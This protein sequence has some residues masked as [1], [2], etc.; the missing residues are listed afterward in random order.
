[1]DKSHPHPAPQRLMNWD[2]LLLWQG[3]FVSFIGTQVFLISMIFWMKHQT[4]SATWVGMVTMASTLP[5]ALLGPLGGTFADRYPRRRILLATD[6]ASGFLSLGLAALVMALPDRP[7]LIL[8]GL[9][10][11]A[12]LM[13]ALGSF[14]RP[15]ITAAI[16]DLV[17]PEKITQANS[18]MGVSMSASNFIGQAF[19]GVL[20]RLLGPGL[21]FVFN[22]VSY[23]FSGVS[24]IFIRIPQKI[25][26]K[27]AGGRR[28][29][30]DMRAETLQGLRYIWADRGL[31]ALLLV[32]VNDMIFL[33]AISV[34]F[35][36]FVEDHLGADPDWYGYL[37]A[38]FGAGNVLG[39]I[40]AGV[41]KL[42]GRTRVRLIVVGGTLAA[43]SA[44]TLG[45][46]VD[47]NW[48]ALFVLLAAGTFLGFND[49]H[50]LS[51]IQLASRKD[52]RGRVLGLFGTIGLAATPVAAGL[53]GIVTDLL[54]QDI[55]TFYAICGIGLGLSP[56]IVLTSTRGRAHLAYEKVPADEGRPETTVS[57]KEREREKGMKRVVK[58]LA[59]AAAT[60]LIIL[61]VT[62]VYFVRRPW[63]QADGELRVAGLEAPV[64][65]IRDEWGV[66][67]VYA[68]SEHDLFFAQGFVH[69]QDRLWQMHMGRV[70]GSGR[71]ATLF[72]E[73]VV[74][75]DRTFR[76][77]SLRWAAERDWEKLDDELRDMLE[78]YSA[79]VNAYIDSN[80]G[81]TGL[82]FRLLGV[83]PEPWT[84]V[85]T[86]TWTKM[87]SLNIGLNV[88]REMARVQLRTRLG[89]K[90]GA[91]ADER[92][93]G[94]YPDDAPVIV[95]PAPPPSGA[96]PPVPE[97]SPPPG[98]GAVAQDREAR[99]P[100]AAWT[101][102]TRLARLEPTAGLGRLSPLLGDA[103]SWGSNAWVVHGSRTASGKP[104]LANDTHL[105]LGLPSVWYENGLHGGRFDVVGFSF[106]GLPT[107]VTGHNG[108][109][110]WGITSL[111]SDTQDLFVEK[112]DDDDAP[113][114]YRY[115]GDWRDLGVRVETIEVAGG[116]D[117]EVKILSTLHGPLVNEAFDQIKDEPPMA[118]SWT[119]HG[120]VRILR[121]L[122]LLGR[123]ENWQEFR[124]ALSFWDAP[125]LS[126]VYADVD[127]NIGYQAT[128]RHPIRAAG[129]DGSMPVPGWTGEFDWR[130]TIPPQDLPWAFNPP[131]GVIVTANNKTVSDDY[132]YTL[133]VDWADPSRAQRIV[134]LLAEGRSFTREDMVRMQ[135]D[136]HSVL[137]EELR[138]HLLAV[139]PADE[140]EQ[141]A[142][143]EVEKWDL[144][145]EPDRVGASVFYVWQWRL[146]RNIVA[147][148]LADPEKLDQ[149]T[150]VVYQQHST[151]DEIMARPDDPWFDD[152]TTPE[153]ETREDI[154]RRSLADAVAWLREN[155][156]DD[157]AGWRWG[158]LHPMVFTH[159]PLGQ[160]GQ[161]MIDDLF[162][163]DPLEGRGGPF[164]VFATTPSLDEPFAII[165]GTSQRFIADLADL[166]R[167]LAINSTG[168]SAHLFHRHREDQIPLWLEVGFHPVRFSRGSVEGVAEGTLYL[169]PQ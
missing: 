123:A 10:T 53:S 13:G 117:V 146:L 93:L 47:S 49:I 108:R 156:G 70:L 103:P 118:L 161:S 77:L 167:S 89:E 52:M 155:H 106:P 9:L 109:V 57:V 82:E 48:E 101:G 3:Q 60:L 73:S 33:V 168:Q 114:R 59:A 120:E 37:A 149:D 132:P 11:T 86:L 98:A 28:L 18:L 39:S 27:T 6:F 166:E 56:L 15:A 110:A 107:V 141:R 157:P 69:A 160:T 72:G 143:Q 96:A 134:D 42:S 1:M 46:G 111:A 102:F 154:T 23:I 21:L 17:P 30:A 169:T 22:G 38:T 43:I 26:E 85:D 66:P 4:G 159:Q 125:A 150:A 16:P 104:L 131:S 51:A 164:T 152:R 145:F 151:L 50:M 32:L 80:P 137:A 95:S 147:D 12:F 2:F 140:L 29:L 24:E 91:E 119:A 19:G 20:F 124:H 25:P 45:R 65:V 138:P 31:V 62:V 68:E 128:G 122:H 34:L 153:V 40:L 83:E 144:R 76:I 55:G 92:I 84:G 78:A 142:L 112:L 61:L 58:L 127:G 75:T 136:T 97:A 5:G 64:E 162:N 88:T 126:F 8:A 7:Q 67:H 74:E 135:A 87:L 36:F 105:G 139:E 81:H 79:G 14:F 35:P 94:R 116:D 90:L 99:R 41:L 158:K 163:G 148:E 113:R 63:P 130:R 54:K 165:G 115:Q 71:L 121:A 100:L 129:H 133:A 44:V